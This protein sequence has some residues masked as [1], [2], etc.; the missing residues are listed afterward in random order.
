MK[1]SKKNFFFSQERPDVYG[2]TG[3]MFHQCMFEFFKQECKRSEEIEVILQF[4]PWLA[5]YQQYDIYC[6]RQLM[7]NALGWFAKEKPH[8]CVCVLTLCQS[9]GRQGCCAYLVK[10]WGESQLVR[11]SVE[12]KRIRDVFF[13]VLTTR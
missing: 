8:K 2:L 3:T 12:T 10:S 7:H 13:F 6:D 5:K 1:G 11:R 4:A 9:F